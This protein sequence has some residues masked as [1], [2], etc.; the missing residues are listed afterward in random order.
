MIEVISRLG[1]EFQPIPFSTRTNLGF[2]R[3]Y[4]EMTKVFDG[5]RALHDVEGVK[6]LNP[7]R[8]RYSWRL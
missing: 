7:L 6:I 5:G 2:S 3:L 1:L 4:F 8:P